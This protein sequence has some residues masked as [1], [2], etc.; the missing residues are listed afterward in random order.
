MAPPHPICHFLGSFAPPDLGLLRNFAP[1]DLPSFESFARPMCY[2]NL[3]W[4]KRGSLPCEN[5]FLARFGTFGAR[6]RWFCDL[7]QKLKIF[8]FLRFFQNFRARG[9]AWP[10]LGDYFTGGLAAIGCARGA[11]G[12]HV[13]AVLCGTYDGMLACPDVG[14][15]VGENQNCKIPSN[16]VKFRQIASTDYMGRLGFLLIL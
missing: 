2:F 5:T 4:R 1:P 3:T 11:A 14:V 13:T 9:A 6:F 7:S 10:R 12:A 8:I 16:C 15:P